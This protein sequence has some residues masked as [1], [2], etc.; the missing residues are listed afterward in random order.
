[1]WFNY[2]DENTWH[3][4]PTDRVKEIIELNKKGETPD[5]LTEDKLNLAPAETT[6]N[7]DLERMDERFKKKDARKKSG[8]KRKGKGPGSG[9]KNQNQP[10]KTQGKSKPKTEGQSQAKAEGQNKGQGQGQNKRRKNRNF[11]K[12]NRPNNDQNS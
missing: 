11:R 2:G 7:S 10:A 5:T 4:I 12:K 3:P 6:I 9:P 1:M 8:K